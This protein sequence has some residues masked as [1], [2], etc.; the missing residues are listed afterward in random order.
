LSI[1]GN[2]EKRRVEPV[3]FLGEID[4]RT[5]VTQ[6]GQPGAQPTATIP[7]TNPD[8]LPDIIRD[9]IEAQPAKNRRPAFYQKAES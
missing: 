2:W 6:D 3:S 1:R 9:R 4:R 5:F 8:Q 7:E